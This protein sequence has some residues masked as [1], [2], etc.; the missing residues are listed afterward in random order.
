VLKNGHR[1]PKPPRGGSVPPRA[2]E[3]V[4][5]K[6]ALPRVRCPRGSGLRVPVTGR[7]LPTD[8]LGRYVDTTV[9]PPV[10]DAARRITVLCAR[11]GG[12]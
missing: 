2:L 3:E 11:A 9:S 12:V 6:S 1:G 4:A 10:T 8:T 5:A 7:G